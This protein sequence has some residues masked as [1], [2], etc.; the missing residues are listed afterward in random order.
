MSKL[1]QSDPFSSRDISDP[2]QEDTT[3]ITKF[4][5]CLKERS[6]DI[7]LLVV[8]CFYIPTYFY[9]VGFVLISPCIVTRPG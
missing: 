1:V 2:L 8:V 4:T 7:S 3:P 5:L 6:K 9:T